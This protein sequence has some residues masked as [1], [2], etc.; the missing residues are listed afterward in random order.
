MEPVSSNNP[1]VFESFTIT[2][3]GCND[4]GDVYAVYSKFLKVI[5]ADISKD[6]E[7]S[8]YYLR[9]YSRYCLTRYALQSIAG[10]IE[11]IT[12]ETAK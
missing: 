6:S 2:R 10:F 1:I 7:E 3:V 11:A 9:I 12:K 4:F 8:E 5:F